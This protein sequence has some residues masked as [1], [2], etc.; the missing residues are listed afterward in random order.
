M[1]INERFE[2]GSRR[3]DLNWNGET[4]FVCG[5]YNGLTGW[6][7]FSV[8]PY[9]RM[10][11]QAGEL[12][13]FTFLVV[14]LCTL[15]IA[16][17]IALLV[18]AMIRPLKTLS[19][20]MVQVQEGDF[21]VQMPN[22]KTDEVGELINSFN[23]MVNKINTLVNEV[24][25]EK[26][27]QK[28]AELQAL[29]AQINPHFLYNTLDSINWMLIDRGEYDISEIIISLGNLMRY[30]IEDDSA[31]VT[32]DREVEYILSYLK[33]KKNRLENRLS[34]L[35]EV[36]ESVRAEAIPKL[37]L[38]PLVE[39]AITHGIAL[40]QQP[41]NVM[42]VIEDAGEEVAITIQDN[43]I[44]MTSE[45][46]EDLRIHCLES[47]KEGNTRIGL[48]NVNRRLRLHY[49]EPFLIHMESEYQKGTTVKLRIPKRQIQVSAKPA[50]G[51]S[52]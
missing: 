2:Q 8:I 12:R 32:I 31:F 28:N 15:G 9:A 43:G 49:G 27:A 33:I 44:G 51:G 37:I 11:L 6:K 14:L 10:F 34:Y 7:S 4:Y 3:F 23:F 41:G 38:Q 18:Y 42:I 46:L 47:D 24:Y 22:R 17:M 52:D 50:Q 19:N 25:Q 40:R 16:A 45:Q 36:D 35:V 29:Q 1:E 48:H 20:V 39:N 21:T 5:Q 13:Q 26:I 30:S